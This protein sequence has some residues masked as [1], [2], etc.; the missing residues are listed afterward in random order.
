MRHVDEPAA[1]AVVVGSRSKG[2]IETTKAELFFAVKG[3]A[4]K[5]FPFSVYKEPAIGETLNSAFAKK[6]AYCESS[7]AALHPVDIEH[8][9]PKG[10]VVVAGK[11]K[12]AK[13]GYYWLA[14]RWGNLLPSCIDCNRARTQ[15]FVD[16]SRRLSGKANKFP[17]SLESRRA[18]APGQ[19]S[20]EG[21]LLLHPFVDDPAEHLEF[22]E[23]G[24]VRAALSNARRR[25]RM[26]ESSID[27]YGLQRKGLVDSRRDRELILRAHMENAK[28]IVAM[29]NDRPADQG[30]QQLLR[31]SLDEL[32]RLQAAAEPYSEMARQLIEKFRQSLT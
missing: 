22:V 18:R 28:Q 5:P 8:Y 19:E 4:A 10:A 26:G 17:I 31:R 23:G 2:G 20:R 15:E 32:K 24:I 1:P 27:V 14:A 25:S 12:P 11:R 13:P 29:L 6:C 3:N 16:A 30:L 7:F 9:R 21:R